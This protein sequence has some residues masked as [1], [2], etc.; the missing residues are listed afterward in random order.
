MT[1]RGDIIEHHR[2]TDGRGA[3][4]V[5]IPDPLVPELNEHEMSIRQR[6]EL[7]DVR[8][9]RLIGWLR[10]GAVVGEADHDELVKTL[11][12][13]RANRLDREGKL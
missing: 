6:D 2:V 5:L 1:I 12:L 9:E 10:P 8:M 3:Q 13:I 11:S 4:T 7:I